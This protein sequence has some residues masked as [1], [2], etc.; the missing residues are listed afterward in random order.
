MVSFKIKLNKT[1]CTKIMNGNIF[2]EFLHNDK[3]GFSRKYWISDI[4]G[5]RDFQNSDI[6]GI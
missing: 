6:Q 4:Q 5:V 3:M 2:S 1:I